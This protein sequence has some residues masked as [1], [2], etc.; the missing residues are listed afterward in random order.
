MEPGGAERRV[1]TGHRP[2]SPCPLTSGPLLGPGQALSQGL[3]THGD[4]HAGEGSQPTT[5]PPIQ[6]QPGQYR[7]FLSE[8]WQETGSL[9][10]AG[11]GC[12]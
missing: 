1:D 6:G 7:A 3:G 4:G 11:R 12:H 10:P 5:P 9:A 2:L 8:P